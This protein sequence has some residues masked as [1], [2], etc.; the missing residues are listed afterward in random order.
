[1]PS[2]CTQV[3]DMLASALEHAVQGRCYDST[4]C[5]AS[6]QQEAGAFGSAP[7]QP[8]ISS[9]VA[10]ELAEAVAGSADKSVMQAADVIALQVGHCMLTCTWFNLSAC[11][12]R[13]V[14]VY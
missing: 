8:S 4:L 7:N 11:L 14:V 2:L 1:M 3:V 9:S 5:G 12:F 13:W 6:E 10:A